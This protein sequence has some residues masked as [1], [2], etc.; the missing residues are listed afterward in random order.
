MKK[1]LLSSLF[2][3]FFSFSFAQTQYHLGVSG[4]GISDYTILNM[5]VDPK[6]GV[7]EV[8]S[9]IKP[10]E[11]KMPEFREQ[12]T[13]NRQRLNLNTEGFDKLAYYRRK[14]QYSCKARKFRIIEVTYFDTKGKEIDKEENSKAKWEAVPAGS[15]REMEFKKVCDM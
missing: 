9:R 2:A 8:F 11:G 1:V 15:M 12:E 5:V 13:K 6:M 4:D 3:S 7:T 10:V 14:I